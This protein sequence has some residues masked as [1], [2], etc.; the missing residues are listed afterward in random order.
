MGLLNRTVDKFAREQRDFFEG[1]LTDEDKEKQVSIPVVTVAMEPG[2]GG[3]LVAEELARRLGFNLYHK[4]ILNAIAHSADTNSEVLDMIEKE[5]FSKIQDFV[6]SLLQ[7]NYVY[8]GA[9][10]QHLTKIV[11]SLGIIGR[12]VI[13]G[14]GANFILPPEKRF[15]IRIIAPEEVRVKNVAFHFD[16][17]LAEAKKRIKNRENRRKAFIKSTFQKDIDDLEAYDLIINTARLDLPAA[18]ETAIGTI[19][20]AQKNR[21]FEKATTFILRSEK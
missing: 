17:S 14:R 16:V 9:Y 4:N 18:V 15:A 21:V 3:Y 19:L 11:N 5:R 2:S 13:V 6:S 20:G 12:A 10:V 7:D 1:S 8:S